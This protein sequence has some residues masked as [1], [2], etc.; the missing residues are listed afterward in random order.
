MTLSKDCNCTWPS[1]RSKKKKAYGLPLVSIVWIT[2]ELDVKSHSVFNLV[3]N[4]CM[5]RM[6]QRTVLPLPAD[7]II[8]TRVNGRHPSLTFPDQ[9]KKRIRRLF[10]R[11]K[12]LS[13]YEPGCCICEMLFGCSII[14]RLGNSR[15]AKNP[16]KNVSTLFSYVFKSKM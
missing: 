14:V 8:S 5:I 1:R 11:N 9:P 6:Y 10:P 4:T 7:S 12:L 3:N 13:S 2:D 16:T 15:R